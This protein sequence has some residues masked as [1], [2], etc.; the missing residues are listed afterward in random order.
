MDTTILVTGATGRVGGQV[1]A[2]LAGTG[3]RVLALARDPSR[4]TGGEPFAG[5]LTRPE[6]LARR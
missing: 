6:T 3:A 1:L 4:L 5:D 2:Q